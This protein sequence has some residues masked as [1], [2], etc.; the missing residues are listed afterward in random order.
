MSRTKKYIS[1][2]NKVKKTQKTQNSNTI[3]MNIRKYWW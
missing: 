3:K 2:K 1:R